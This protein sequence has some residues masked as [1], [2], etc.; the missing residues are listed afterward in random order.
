MTDEPE[1]FFRIVEEV[2]SLGSARYRAGYRLRDTGEVICTVELP[3]SVIESTV[4]GHSK[5]AIA[6]TTNGY[7]QSSVVGPACL[8]GTSSIAAEPIDLLIE[9]MTAVENLHLEEATVETLTMLLQRL[10]RS[11]SLAREAIA[12]LDHLRS[13]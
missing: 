4:F 11:V 3:A 8:S 13:S 9:H 6:A 7:I 12:Q 1:A 5:L 2:G 10:E